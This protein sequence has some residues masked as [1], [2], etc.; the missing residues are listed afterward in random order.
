M[1]SSMVSYTQLASR[2]VLCGLLTLSKPRASIATGEIIEF[3]ISV[4]MT[5]ASFMMG[6]CVADDETS[7][8]DLVSRVA[9]RGG[10]LF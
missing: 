10:L 1:T 9:V 4:E 5:L 3:A 8:D 2:C 7:D 6:R